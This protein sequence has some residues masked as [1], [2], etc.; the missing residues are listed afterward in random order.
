M[1]KTWSRALAIALLVLT[2]FVAVLIATAWFA[3]P[4]DGVTVT[5]H[6]HTFS[7][8][9]LEGPQI[10]VAFCIAVAA[11]VV[12]IIAALVLVVVGLAF[13]ALGIAFGLLTA[14]AS[15]ALVLT[16]FALI[17]WLLWRLFHDRP[18]PVATP[19]P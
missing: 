18:A 2:L 11:V 3:L 13:G 9:D 12:A 10:V 15:L 17:G 4:L 16:P 19:A 6:G 7:M 1:I 8:A 14:A 5:V